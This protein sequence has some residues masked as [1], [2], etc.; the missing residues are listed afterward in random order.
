MGF[1]SLEERRAFRDYWAV[2]IPDGDAW[3]FKASVSAAS[4]PAWTV[5]IPDGDAWVFKAGIAHK[6]GN[7][8]G[9]SFNPRW[10]C[11]GFQSRLRDA[12]YNAALR[13]SIPDGDAWVFKGSE[14]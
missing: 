9:Q 14:E 6:P 13:V 10:G 12:E 2:S 11:M 4:V 5:S 8:A 1:Q 7:S 3:V